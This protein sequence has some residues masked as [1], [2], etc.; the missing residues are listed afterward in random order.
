MNLQGLWEKKVIRPI[1]AVLRQGATAPKIALGIACGV[2]LGVFPMLGA[3]TVLCALAAL[4]FR[5]NLA[6]IQLVNCIVYPFQILLLI[7]FFR[8]GDRL[9]RVEPL[10]LSVG[11]VL[12]LIE[13]DCWGAVLLLWDTTLRAIA[14]WLMV[15]PIATLLLYLVFKPVIQRL[16]L[17]GAPRGGA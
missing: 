16:A 8:A 14:V 10:A 3:T 6:A 17:R 5:L 13:A 9:F 1:L 11:D 12:A 7:P 15:G 2:S 4:V